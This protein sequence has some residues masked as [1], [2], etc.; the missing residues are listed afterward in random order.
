[1]RLF[2]N[3]L[4]PPL[5]GLKTATSMKGL[6]DAGLDPPVQRENLEPIGNFPG[7]LYN[8][9]IEEVK[10]RKFFSLH[11]RGHKKTPPDFSSPGGVALYSPEPPLQG[12]SLGVISPSGRRFRRTPSPR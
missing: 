6:A 8:A 11:K 10:A 2:K 5:N 12:I 7:I 4:W 9:Q 1:M 3:E